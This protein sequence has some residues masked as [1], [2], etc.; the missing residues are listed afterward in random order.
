MSLGVRIKAARTAANLTLAAVGSACGV[1][2]QA[3]KAWE[4]NRSEPS[5]G[6]M[7]QIALIT[8]TALDFLITG[9]A[10]SN[11][12]LSRLHRAEGRLVP[13]KPWPCPGLSPEPSHSEQE[14]IHTH[15]PCGPR[16]FSVLVQ[17]TSNAP[18]MS[19]GDSI[20]VDPDAKPKPGDMVM[21]V[22]GQDVVLRRYRPRPDAIELAPLNDDWP[23][24]SIPAL[25]PATF[26][27]TMS[28]HTKP[29]RS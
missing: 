26:I 9:A 27:G 15:F 21:V 11:V 3:V 28:E 16:S 2:P 17:D 6:S 22:C 10:Q 29:R 20:V 8:G 4:D 7:I 1:S 5:L 19:V 18:V 24:Q 25:T 13:R 12:G 23:V 14:Y